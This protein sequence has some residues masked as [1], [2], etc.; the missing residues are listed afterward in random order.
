MRCIIYIICVVVLAACASYTP[1]PLSPASQPK[2]LIDSLAGANKITHPRLPA[3]TIDLAKPLAEQDLAR[4]ALWLSPELASARAQVGVAQGQLFAAGLLPDLQWNWSLDKPR[5]A[6]LVNALMRALA[7]DF[8]SL[9]SRSA[10]KDSA[11]HGLE[12]VHADIAWTEWLTINQ[13][14]SLSRRIHYLQVQ[15]DFAGE[16]VRAAA[17]IYQVSHENLT[18]GDATLDETAVLQVAFM[19]AQDRQLV[20]VRELGAARLQLNAL[21]GLAPETALQLAP[22]PA[23][24][25]T[26]A[27]DATTMASKAVNQRFDLLALREAYAASE[28]DVRKAT[29]SQISL[30]S[31]SFNKARDTSAVYTRG[32]GV[33]WTLPIWN[34]GRGDIALATATR[35]QLAAEYAARVFAV[36]SDVAALH[37]DLAAIDAQIAAIGSQ[38][39]DLRKAD[40]ALAQA[41]MA[42]DVTS[43]TY[44]TVRAALLDKQLSLAALN[45]AR[46]EAE[47]A[48]ETAVGDWLWPTY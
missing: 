8:T 20:L 2:P 11:R 6:S 5:D 3:S 46:A 42:G 16:A 18:K 7:L 14:R 47:V 25:E 21:I 29:R 26:N 24:N 27:L 15:V 19:D 4:L 33:T 39:D 13:A 1:V 31:L 45:G 10:Q 43:L 22:P 40:A 12:K 35:S 30:P 36:Q 32:V 44:V 9:L 41:M 48:L 23:A 28:A 37:V 17:K 34:R 38:L